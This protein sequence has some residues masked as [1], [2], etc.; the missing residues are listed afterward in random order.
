MHK[1]FFLKMLMLL[2]IPFVLSS[3]VC[4][5]NPLSER[6]TAD[7]RLAGVWHGQIDGNDEYLHI[8]NLTDGKSLKLIRVTHINHGGIENHEELEMFPTAT[9]KFKYLNLK[10][11]TPG[12]D[13]EGTHE[14]WL[15]ARYDINSASELEVSII[16]YDCLKKAIEKK[17]LHGR[18]WETTWGANADINDSSKD[19]QNFVD[20]KD[21]DFKFYGVFHHVVDAV[22]K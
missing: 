21:A 18:V 5:E 4:F 20:S 11:H 17:L 22:A 6:V 15:F 19:L 9:E 1:K 10:V 16:D 8:F 13:G 2:S 7:A 14:G 12:A 3:C